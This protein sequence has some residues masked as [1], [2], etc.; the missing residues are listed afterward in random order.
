MEKGDLK[1]KERKGQPVKKGDL[2][3]KRAIL[4]EKRDKENL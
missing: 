4:K 2:K 1:R 3:R